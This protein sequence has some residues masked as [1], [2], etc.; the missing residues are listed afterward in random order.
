[1]AAGAGEKYWE[2]QGLPSAFKHALLDRYV[3]R[4]TGAT[5]QASELK[6]V[7]FLDGYAGRGRYA[8]G[9]PGS[10]ERVLQIAQSQYE[11]VGLAW[12][13][14][15]VEAE[16][17]SAAVL[18]AVVQEYR[19]AG[20]T[21]TAHRGPVLDMLT[22]VIA[23]ANGLSLF[24]FLDPC[25]LGIPYDRLVRLLQTERPGRWPPTE[26]LLNFSLEGVRRIGG[27]VNSAS[28]Q[29]RTM[30]RLDQ[31]L[32]GAWWR[33][34]FAAG[35]SDTAVDAV[36]TGFSER[37]SRD[38]S[39]SIVSVPV[40]RAPGQKPIYQLVFGTRSQYG[41]WAF[42]DSVARA[43]EAWWDTLDTIEQAEDQGM[44]FTVASA[45]RPSLDVVEAAAVDRIAGNLERLLQ[46]HLQIVVGEHTLAVF[47][48][49]Y[50]QIREPVVRKAIKALHAQGRTASNGVGGRVQDLVVRRPQAGIR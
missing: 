19:S 24:L 41:L 45:V 3:P 43:S 20:V 50:G 34:E 26:V 15:F 37:L 31:A 27:H 33:A 16:A 13:C 17:E 6:K 49:D 48:D 35:V 25:G 46:Q 47:G 40:R 28:G 14:F 2:S 9:S 22:G 21:A 36:A 12:T 8:D 42:G 7:V 11:S 10:A 32:G 38:T 29:D 30:Q 5:G 23:A 44:L 18:E 4:F 39:M 1:M